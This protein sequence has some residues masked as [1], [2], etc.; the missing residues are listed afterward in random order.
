[1]KHVYL[2]LIAVFLVILGHGQQKLAYFTSFPCISPDGNQVVFTY[3]GDLWKVS[4]DGGLATRLTA[5]L[6]EETRAKFS[7]DGNW[8]AFTGSQYGNQDIFVLP[9]DGGEVRQLTFHEA[10]DHVDNWSWDSKEIY[11]TSSRENRN[12]AYT[13]PATGGT[14]K[15]L[16]HNFFHT[17]HNIAV[18]PDGD[19]FFSETSE[20]KSQAYRKGYKGSYNPEIQ[21]YN[22][23]TKAFLKYTKYEGKDM[24]PTIDRQGKVYFVSD[25]KNGQYNLSTLNRN[26]AVHLTE[27][28]TSIKHPV[29]SADGRFVVFEKDFQVFKYDV[30]SKKTIKIPIIAFINA[31]SEKE[32][33]FSV[34][35]NISYFDVSAD[36][37]KLAFVSRGELFVS[38]IKGKFIQKL[39]TNP[40][41]RVT[42]VKWKSDNKSLV[43]AQTNAQGYTNLF[44]IRADTMHQEK[45]LTNEAQNNRELS[46]NKAKTKMVY[47]SGRNDLKIIDLEGDSVATLVKEELWGFQ[48]ST[49]SFSPNDEY[50]LFTARRNFE[51]DI[52]I[53]HLENKKLINLTKTGITESSPFWSPDGKYIYFTSNRLKPAY[54]FGLSEA[55]VYRIPLEK[56]SN[57][58][59]SNKYDSLFIE[60]AKIPKTKTD[61]L[62]T[63]PKAEGYTIDFNNILNR[64]EL[65]SPNFGTQGKSFVMQ[66]DE[67][68]IAIYPSNHSEN[69]FNLW[70]TTYEPFERT[71]TEKIEGARSFGAFIVQAA[72]KY[73]TLIGGNIHTLNPDAKKVEKINIDYTFRRHLKAEFDQM[74]TETW[75]NVQENFYNE[76]F[77]GLN[78]NQVGEHYK[79]FL[80]FVNTRSELRVL[81][82]EML[83]DLNSSHTGFTS[84]GEEENTFY[85][86]NT[87]G[88]GI[89]WN[90]DDP[91][92]VKRVITY[93]PSDKKGLD[94]KGG[95]V[96]KAVNGEPVQTHQNRE[97]YFTKPSLDQELEL[98]FRRGDSTFM[99]NIQPVSF[100]TINTLRYDEWIDQNQIIVDQKSN[101]RIAYAH[102]KDMGTGELNK[103]LIDMTTEIYDRDALILDI[104]YNNGGNVHDNVLQFLSQKPY[105]KWKYREG[106]L[107]VQP[108]FTPAG[109]PIILLTNEQ[110]LSDAEMTTEGFKRLGLG[111]VI[112][113]ET[114]RWIIFTTG[115]SL[116][117]GSFYRL[118]SWGCYTLDGKNLEQ[119]GVSP[120]IYVGM[121]FMDR[122]NQVD[123]QLDRAISEILGMLK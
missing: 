67:K 91:F 25:E 115:K 116:V 119:V 21:S 110:S 17:V 84:F 83:G 75:A 38:D 109:K 108:N 95:D 63:K 71:K 111:K 79:Q 70:M 1:M 35:N 64:V 44:S 16:F 113:T 87:L 49:P 102:M 69:E 97:S 121:D 106:A 98:T 122:L 120:D 74:F 52:F 19:I 99:I 101:K 57:E 31:T 90:H 4:I 62:N 72:D 34:Q 3:E 6:G 32:K 80:P 66:K 48:N 7:P 78:W 9:A 61:S 43:F 107:T 5:M 82:T 24:W 42:E 85:K 92:K 46:I 13:I 26:K 77:H 103:F 55:R 112:G 117:D 76:T 86:T 12:S 28:K 68:S 18:H 114:Y 104:R 47:L 94:L 89:V 123:P 56:F 54:P 11:F 96:L 8:I 14:P 29:V 36:G 88:T 10:F 100:N 50:I 23:K 59:R 51:E 22:P 53:Y 40:L 58:F 118:P 41:A 93:S 37:K 60:K 20:S 73:F 30:Q 2:T 15:R 105:L 39:K 27:F 45:Q 81:I 65:V 33:D